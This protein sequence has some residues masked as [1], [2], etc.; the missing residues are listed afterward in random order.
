MLQNKASVGKKKHRH[1]WIIPAVSRV[2]EH[3]DFTVMLLAASASFP[4]CPPLAQNHSQAVY[5]CGLFPFCTSPLPSPP[6]P[7]AENHFSAVSHSALCLWLSLHCHVKVCSLTLFG[8]SQIPVCLPCYYS[9]L[10]TCLPYGLTACLLANIWMCDQAV[11][12]LFGATIE[13][14]GVVCWFQLSCVSR[15]LKAEFRFLFKLQ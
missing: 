15:V 13:Y 6:L 7:T 3:H 12:L 8:T 14:L 5:L 4:K 1:H 11:L 9:Y 2:S 10:L